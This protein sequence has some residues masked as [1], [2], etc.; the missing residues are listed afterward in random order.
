MTPYGIPQHYGL[1]Y[2]MG[3]A[4]M[5]EGVLSA[6]YHFCPSHNNFQFGKLVSV[7]KIIHLLFMCLIY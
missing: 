4:L 1:F 7:N 2:A 6:S 3:I 5:M